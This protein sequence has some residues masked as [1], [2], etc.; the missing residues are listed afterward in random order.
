M[1]RDL[2]KDGRSDK[3]LPLRPRMRP[4][5]GLQG[6]PKGRVLL[7]G[8]QGARQPRLGALERATCPLR[9]PRW[10]GREAAPQ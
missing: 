7:P 4:A 10:G 3:D 2:T 8:W 9:G 1:G 6:G 5:S